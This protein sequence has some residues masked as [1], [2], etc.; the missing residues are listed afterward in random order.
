[1]Y[2]PNDLEKVVD[3]HIHVPKESMLLRAEAAVHLKLLAQ[4]FFDVFGTQ[5]L[6]RSAYRDF[7]Y[8]KRIKDG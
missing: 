8:Q 3:A 4:D 1:M 6:L 5:I 2:A 7:S